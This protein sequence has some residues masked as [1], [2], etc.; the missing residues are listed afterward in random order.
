MRL[1][2]FRA[3]SVHHVHHVDLQHL[4]YT[5]VH[6]APVPQS[7]SRSVPHCAAMLRPPVGWFSSAQNK[8][9]LL[10]SYWYFLTLLIV[11][12]NHCEHLNVWDYWEEPSHS[13]CETLTASCISGTHRRSHD[14]QGNSWQSVLSDFGKIPSVKWNETRTRKKRIISKIDISMNF[15]ACMCLLNGFVQ[16]F[17]TY[18]NFLESLPRRS[19]P[20][21]HCKGIAAWSE[22]WNNGSKLVAL[23]KS[24]FISIHNDYTIDTH[25]SGV[26][27]MVAKGL[28]SCF[29]FAIT[30]AL[31]S[32]ND[33]TFAMTFWL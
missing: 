1:K 27:N 19:L 29:A 26:K 32:R 22:S 31:L 11:I 18:L 28:Y 4:C 13:P 16:C 21:S 2:N 12:A 6:F 15:Y 9:V 10:G 24:G 23:H 5:G 8:T 17:E 14:L 33:V 30:F 3:R 7:G 25:L 20:R